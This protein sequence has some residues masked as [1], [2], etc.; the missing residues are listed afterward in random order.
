M[1]LNGALALAGRNAPGPRSVY[2]AS[3]PS[4]RGRLIFIA[5]PSSQRERGHVDPAPLL[6]ALQRGLDELHALGALG[7]GPLVGR[8]F[9]HVADEG[10]PLQLEAVVVALAVG[11]VLP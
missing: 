1:R 6:P 2:D 3:E 11:H 4:S 8:V 9:G 7:Q 10:L 5:R